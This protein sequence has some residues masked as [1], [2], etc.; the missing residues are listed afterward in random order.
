MQSQQTLQMSSVENNRAITIAL[1]ILKECREDN[2]RIITSN[3]SPEHYS[4][5]RG[6]IDYA[7]SNSMTN[8]YM[9]YLRGVFA[10][11]HFELLESKNIEDELKL[12]VSQKLANLLLKIKI[13]ISNEYASKIANQN[14]EIFEMFAK[15]DSDLQLKIEKR[16]FYIAI[17]KQA[18]E[19]MRM[20]FLKKDSL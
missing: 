15:E 19:K 3:C 9:A 1:E 7:N 5:L 11:K 2:M 17:R 14:R 20:E 4:F 8:N 6:I 18:F 13:P 12:I 16:K 10:M